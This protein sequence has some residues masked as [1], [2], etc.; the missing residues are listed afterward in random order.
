MGRIRDRTSLVGGWRDVVKI[1]SF[2]RPKRGEG[3]LGRSLTYQALVRIR[4]AWRATTTSHSRLSFDSISEL[5]F[6][7]CLLSTYIPSP[8]LSYNSAHE[9]PLSVWPIPSLQAHSYII[10]QGAYRLAA[11]GS[12]QLH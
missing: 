3:Q 4:L 11:P 6:F 7:L 8:L 5:H 12:D 10:F 2:S 1:E 9:R